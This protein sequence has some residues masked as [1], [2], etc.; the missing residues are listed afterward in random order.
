MRSKHF[1]WRQQHRPDWPTVTV[2]WN[3]SKL[4][5][6][7]VRFRHLVVSY[8]HDRL[9]K[10]KRGTDRDKKRDRQRQER[11]TETRDRQTQ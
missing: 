4:K 10:E 6:P 8:S 5:V 7:V 11:E 2:P 9:M 1:T 3:T